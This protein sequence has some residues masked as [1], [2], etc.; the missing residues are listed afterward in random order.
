MPKVVKF[1][2]IP[3]LLLAALAAV[4]GLA[5]MGSGTDKASDEVIES[6]SP[7]PNEKVLQQGQ[8]TVDLLTGW[9]GRLQIDQ[10]TIPDDQIERIRELGK[11]TF[12][13]GP[14]KEIEYFPAGQNCTTLT[15]WQIANPEQTFTK[16]WC[17]T[18]V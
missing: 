5:R 17:F 4:V 6:I 2:V 7:G 16:T 13:P 12:Q 18:S 9:D 14:G 3:L 10:V 1:V 15:Y 8:L 11:L